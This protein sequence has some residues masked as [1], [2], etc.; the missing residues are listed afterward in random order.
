MNLILNDNIEC[1]ITLNKNKTNIDGQ[2]E[3]IFTNKKFYC[4]FKD[5]N[6][7][8]FDTQMV[9]TI[10]SGVIRINGDITKNQEVYDGTCKIFGIEHNIIKVSKRRNLLNSKIV[11]FTEIV[12]E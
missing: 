8:D 4:S 7:V 6:Q 9:Q 3:P 2:R 10:A 5:T 11:D 12:I 1:F